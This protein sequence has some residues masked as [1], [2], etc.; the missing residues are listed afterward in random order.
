MTK[1]LKESLTVLDLL[2][3]TKTTFYVRAA[4]LCELAVYS[5]IHD[6]LSYTIRPAHNKPAH[7]IAFR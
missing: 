6:H 1:P 2:E 7:N 3:G 4:L 5:I